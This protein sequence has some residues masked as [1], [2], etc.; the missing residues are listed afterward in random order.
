MHYDFLLVGAGLT[1]AVIAERISHFNLGKVLVIDKRSHIAGNCYTQNEEEIDVHRYGAHIFHTDDAEVAKYFT[2]HCPNYHPFINQPIA[3][4]TDSFG[5]RHAYNMP[6]NMNTFV[7]L[8]EGCTT[9]DEVAD[10]I[11]AETTAC[12]IKHPRNLEEQAISLVGRTVYTTLIKGYTEKQWGRP[13]NELPASIIKRLPIR[14]TFDNNYFSDKYQYMPGRGGYTAFIFDLLRQPNIEIRLNT[15]YKDV[16]NG[17]DTFGHVFYSGCIDELYDYEL[18][19][20]EYRS[21]RF[22]E[23]YKYSKNYQGCPVCNYTSTDV[24]YTRSIEHKWFNPPEIESNFSIVSYEYPIEWKPGLEPYYP[25]GDVKNTEL[26]NKYVELHKERNGDYIT[27]V[28]RLGQYKYLD[29]DDSIR[30][31]LNTFNKFFSE[32]FSGKLNL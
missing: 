6:F 24:P 8:F 9:P 11:K 16:L 4:F 18:G 1:N 31:S 22:D 29:M 14:F 30:A 13:C 5:V 12:R 28:G 19:V 25:I 26:Y 27:M 15:S 2:D 7:Q 23:T 20:L 3:I 32:F 10:K 17:E 21:L